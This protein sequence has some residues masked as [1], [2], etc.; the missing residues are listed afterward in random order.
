MV[1]LG[2]HVEIGARF[3][4][5]RQCSFRALSVLKTCSDLFATGTCGVDF[6][7]SDNK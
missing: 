2:S 6:S 4:P 3:M 7:L 5:N 1:P